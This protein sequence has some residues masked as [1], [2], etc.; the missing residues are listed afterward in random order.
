MEKVLEFL[1]EER[2][3]VTKKL[4]EYSIAGNTYSINTANEKLKYINILINKAVGKISEEKEQQEE[5]NQNNDI[6][7]TPITPVV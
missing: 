2:T 3:E 7:E 4:V 5:I 1:E 6:G